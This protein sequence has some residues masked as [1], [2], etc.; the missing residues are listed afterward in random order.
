MKSK[1]L[2]GRMFS[3]SATPFWISYVDEGFILNEHAEA[4]K[5]AAEL[6]FEMGARATAQELNKM[7]FPK[8][9]TESIVGK[10]L[11]QPAIYGS[12]IAMEWDESGKPIQVKKEIKG[13]YPAVIS[14]SEFYRVGAKLS[15]RQ[16]PKLA[17]RKVAEFK[18]ILRGIVFCACGS[19][20]RYHAQKR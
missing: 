16:D 17:G 20:F 13:Y 10:V 1:R 9:Y 2:R 14:E 5:R 18:N 7:N 8:K 12:F 19:G 15:E 11:R 6:C 4:V 3:C